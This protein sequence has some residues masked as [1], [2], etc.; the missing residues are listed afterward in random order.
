MSNRNLK[1]ILT[2][3]TGFVGEGVLLASL[4]HPDVKEVLMVN[5]KHFDL[6]QPG[7]KELIVP[8]F[9]NLDMVTAQLTS[10]DAC[11]FCAGISS[12]GMS[13]EK[14]THITYDTTI[15]FAKVLAELNPDMVFNF[16]SGSHTDGSEKGRVMWARVKGKT[17][18]ALM[19]MPFRKEFNF[20]PGAMI[21]LEGQMNVKPFYK[22]LVRTIAFLSSKRAVTLQEIAHAM[23]N[24]VIAGYP[25]QILEIADIKKLAKNAF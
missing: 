14:Y 9:M 1:I 5:R 24:A 10:Y 19:K 17:E 12:A 6:Q 8:D 21:P 22:F 15:H 11:F 2:G 7:L 23:V 25:K 3:A 16:V 13:E 20:R 18:N 4:N